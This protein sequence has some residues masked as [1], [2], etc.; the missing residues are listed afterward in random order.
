[1]VV[2]DTLPQG[3]SS[4]VTATTV[5]GITPVI[6]NGQVTVGLGT[7]ASGASAS[8]VTINVQPLPTAV[9]QISDAA[10]VS[11]D[12]Y[13]PDTSNNSPAPVTTTVD[14]VADLQ[15]GITAVTSPVPA[16]QDVTYRITATNNGPSDASGVSVA[17][18]LP[19]GVT[20]V[21]ATGGAVPVSG[22]ITFD[23]GALADNATE[24]FE[25]TLQTS[26]TTV[27]PMSDMVTITGDQYDPNTTN[28]TMTLPVPITPVSNLSLALDG[29]TDPV[30]TGTKVRY[31]I[32]ASNTGPSPDPDAVVVDTLP[33]NVT[34]VSATGGV[35][36]INGVLTFDVGD[37]ASNATSDVAI[38]VE[39]TAAAAGTV[40]GTITDNASIQGQY[41]VNANTSTSVTTTVDAV[42]G[43]V[44]QLAAAPTQGYVGQ[45]VKYTITVNDDGPSNATGVVV[46]DT[47]PSDIGSKLTA[48]TSVQGVTPAIAHSTVTASFGYLAYGATVTMTI[49]VVPTQAA[50]TDS[51]LVDSANITDDQIDPDDNSAN[52]ATP[53]DSAVNLDITQFTADA[54]S[55]EFGDDLTYTAIVTNNGPSTASGVT[56]TAPLSTNAA[57]LSGSFA[58]SSGS[59]APAG[60]VS[61]SGT[62]LVAL[63]GDLAMGASE[64]VTFEIS[65]GAGAIG[66][67]VQS[68]TATSNEYDT[69]PTNNTAQTTTTVLDRPGTI[70]FS[71]TNYEVPDTAGS[72]TITLVRTDGSRGQVSVN[73]STYGM[74]ATAGVDYQP[75]TA[76]VVFPAGATS[77]TVQVPV[78]D[79]PYDDHNELVGLAISSPSGGAVIGTT[80]LATLTIVDVDPDATV[81]QV[82]ALQWTGSAQSIASLVLSF[83]EPLAAGPANNASN[84]SLV[85]IGRDGIFGT[86]DDST[87]GV[88]SATYNASN[89]TVTL[90]PGSPLSLNQFYHIAVSGTA[91]NGITSLNGEE[92]AGAGP[93]L[94]GTDYTAMFAQGT[95]LTYVDPSKNTVTMTIK[96]GG[97]LDDVLTGAAQGG[98]LVVVGEVPHRTVLSGKV[99]RGKHGSGQSFLGYTVYGLGQFGNVKVKM[100]SPPFEITRYPFSPGRPPSNRHSRTCGSMRRLHRPRQSIRIGLTPS[101]GAI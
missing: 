71:A 84:Y 91:P 58:P 56:L 97:Y 22:L 87:V 39:P 81:P 8:A 86:G 89:W 79:D 64:T 34:F 82:T 15:V 83:N 90:V 60:S 3:I 75:T 11:S 70:Q 1:M 9:P 52:V 37:L 69:N 47:L 21:S 61:Q 92:L 53:V 94:A 16:G 7:L 30:N 4:N 45:A 43:L 95:K 23:I 42:T 38:V 98:E 26:G 25:V 100:T 6:A 59:S 80:N 54:S 36:P 55:I 77:E 28:N 29:P 51:P 12:T 48:T 63:I 49:S 88:K 68:I 27:S 99:K 101:A 41:N 85:N 76:T 10:T 57:F 72:A 50:V 44:L 66:Q 24:S 17:D 62:N 35:V 18:Y 14:A 31:T 96:K 5:S 20:F 73:F 13:D 32:A 19:D 40:S 2:T 93:G 74:T 67:L 65:P 46:T 33:A 78:L